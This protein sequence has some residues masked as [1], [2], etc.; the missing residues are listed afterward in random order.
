MSRRDTI[1][2]SR[3][4]DLYNDLVNGEDPRSYTRVRILKELWD[5]LSRA[6][7]QPTNADENEYI[8]VQM[9]SFY[10]RYVE[11]RLK[12]MEAKGKAPVAAAAGAPE[13]WVHPNPELENLM[14]QLGIPDVQYTR[15]AQH[16]REDVIKAWASGALSRSHNRLQLWFD[17]FQKKTGGLS[18]EDARF[19]TEEVIK[20]KPSQDETSENSWRQAVS[21]YEG[22]IASHIAD[23]ERATLRPLQIQPLP[24]SNAPT[25]SSL[26]SVRTD[27]GTPN[28]FADLNALGNPP[29]A[30]AMDTDA[31]GS[32]AATVG[33]NPFYGTQPT[34][35]SQGSQL[36]PFFRNQAV[37]LQP[38]PAPQGNNIQPN[39]IQAGM[40]R[41]LPPGAGNLDW[42]GPVRRRR[43]NEGAWTGAPR[44]SWP[45]V[46]R[47]YG[48]NTRERVVGQR[49][50]TYMTN[51]GYAK[52]IVES[53]PV[54]PLLPPTAT[55][56][57]SGAP[58]VLRSVPNL[59][60]GNH[61]W[62]F[63]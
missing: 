54:P 18:A 40:P 50:H 30:G 52:E 39:P 45:K 2:A 3:L 1:I 27:S 31:A 51:Q 44:P 7:L 25:Q 49:R 32:T 13:R 36:N 8:D 37:P 28:P 20:G 53:R 19:I 59:G 61:H 21:D 12:R 42:D 43:P 34:Q 46:F 15:Q 62:L 22:W 23:A 55:L 29:G 16:T 33:D 35:P 63:G 11:P 38:Q 58:A 17:A 26:P 5:A 24:A 48:N 41:R 56:G 4:Q 14:N 57:Q 47:P 6:A 9:R 60:R 10:T